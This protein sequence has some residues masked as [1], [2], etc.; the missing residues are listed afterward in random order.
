MASR[1]S[2]GQ[3]IYRVKK[4]DRDGKNLIRGQW[5]YRDASEGIAVNVPAIVSRQLFDKVQEQ[6]CVAAMLIS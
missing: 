3:R 5:V 2:E 6:H 1:F 4:G